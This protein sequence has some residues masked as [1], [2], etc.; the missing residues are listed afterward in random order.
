M[1]R[2][3]RVGWKIDDNVYL[4]LVVVL[5]S[6][7]WMSTYMITNIQ[8]SMIVLHH[9]YNVVDFNCLREP[10]DFPNLHDWRWSVHVPFP[11]SFHSP[12]LRT[13]MFSPD[14]SAD[15]L[16]LNRSTKNLCHHYR[17]MR[18]SDGQNDRWFHLVTKIFYILL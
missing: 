12:A 13:M 3:N 15:R 7:C 11:L 18:K 16:P 1:K 17:E 2:N 5:R 9:E 6:L 4:Q 14:I 8:L 10:T